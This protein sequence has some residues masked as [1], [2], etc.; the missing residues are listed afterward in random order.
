MCHTLRSGRWRHGRGPVPLCHLPARS[1]PLEVR[2]HSP[3]LPCV[4]WGRRCVF[5]IMLSLIIL[6]SWQIKPQTRACQN[7]TGSPSRTSVSR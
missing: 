1:G 6:F 4:W 7:R 5:F 2:C 3:G